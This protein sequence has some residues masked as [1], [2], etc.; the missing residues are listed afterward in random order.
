[1]YI[2]VPTY[3]DTTDVWSHTDFET[4]EEFVKFMWSLFKEP[5]KYEFDD[6]SY[7]FNQQATNFEKNNKV[8]CYAPMRSK[9]Y[10][11]YWENEKDKCRNGVIYKN[12][13]NTWYLSRDYFMCFVKVIK[14]ATP[15]CNN[16]V[17][18][19]I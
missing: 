8:Y 17:S 9:D 19:Y 5:G 12:K 7:K 18:F 14:P 16:L 4:R 3:D 13:K 11:N 1:M 6:T 2:S 15:C 10:I